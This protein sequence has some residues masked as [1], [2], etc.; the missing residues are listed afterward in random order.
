MPASPKREPSQNY[1]KAIE[2]KTELI[3]RLQNSFKEYECLNLTPLFHSYDYTHFVMYLTTYDEL[4]L[5]GCLNVFN[6]KWSVARE[7]I[8]VWNRNR[9]VTEWALQHV[10]AGDRV[11]Y[12]RP[13]VFN[14]AETTILS[15]LVGPLG[16][17]DIIDSMQ[18]RE[19][20]PNI[21]KFH[22]LPDNIEYYEGEL[23]PIKGKYDVLI[24][25]DTVFKYNVKETMTEDSKMLIY[26][27]SI[28]SLAVD[29]ASYKIDSFKL[30]SK[31]CGRGVYGGLSGASDGYFSFT[32]VG[33][34]M[35]ERKVFKRDAFPAENKILMTI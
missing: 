25:N 30:E 10:N 14:L 12:Y 15:K 2:A 21:L 27:T 1:K 5:P 6:H 28:N 34:P 9:E 3:N 18:S 11:L 17:L 29:F 35:P 31:E 19:C 20:M 13:K 32:T 33:V 7:N 16:K 23:P 24:G 4:I 8:K 26:T 22:S